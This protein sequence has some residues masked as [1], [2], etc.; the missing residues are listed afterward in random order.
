V[1]NIVKRLKKIPTKIV[2]DYETSVEMIDSMGE[3]RFVNMLD[4]VVVIT[5]DEDSYYYINEVKKKVQ[6]QK[7]QRSR[8]EIKEDKNGLQ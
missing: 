3:E 7:K 2:I 1:S 5:Y 8:K 4:N 6:S